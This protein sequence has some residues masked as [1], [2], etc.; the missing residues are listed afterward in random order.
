MKKLLTFPFLIVVF[1]IIFTPRIASAQNQLEHPIDLG[2]NWLA[3]NQEADGHWDSGKHEGAGTHEA[4]LMIT[5]ASLLAFLDSGYSDITTKYKTN[6]ALAIEWLVKA[7]KPN[8]SWNIK[9]NI[10]GIC[11]MALSDAAGRNC[12]GKDVKNAA[13]I[14]SDFLLKQQNKSGA[15][16][17]SEKSTVVD[18]VTNGWCILGLKSALLS[19][20]NRKKI[21]K[22]FKKFNQFLDKIEG[23][24]D[25]TQKSKGIAWFTPDKPQGDGTLSQ[26]IAMLIRQY[27]GWERTNPW[28]VAAAQGQAANIPKEYSGTDIYR[29][30][31]AD[32]ALFQQGGS[33]LKQ[34]KTTIPQMIREAQRKDG[35][36][37]GS[38]DKTGCDLDSGGRV[39]YTAFICSSMLLEYNKTS[40]FFH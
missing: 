18:M 3:K 12:G 9:N 37:K 40:I 34:W 28:L 19:E 23:T 27:S 13:K 29:L 21:I 24:K 7:Q 17:D 11:T 16:V 38:W 26:A 2:L 1:L 15:F 6:V 30:Y 20:I 31:F 14:G 4:D 5:A 25:V 33:E 35:D 39:L 22:A 8:G 10:N 36:F 32:L